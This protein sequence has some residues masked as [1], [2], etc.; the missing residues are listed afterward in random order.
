[1]RA[2]GSEPE[3]TP[4]RLG[5]RMP[6]EWEPHAATWMAWPHA[7]DDWPGKLGAIARVYAAMV[8]ELSRGERV[9]IL[10]QHAAAGG[11]IRRAL[12][13]A[14][15]DLSAVRLH[16][17]PT[18]RSWT[19]DTLPIFVRN[20][21]EVALVDWRFNGWARYPD[22]RLDDA[23]GG[24]LAP[25]LGLRRFVP[26]HRTAGGSRRRVVLEGGAIDA[27]GAGLLL[28][29]EECLLSSTQARNPGLGRRATENILRAH[30]GVEKIVWLGRGIAGDDTHG[31]VDD[32]ARFVGQRTVVAVRE[33]NPD[34]PNHAPLAENLRRL[35]E[36]TDAVGRPLR[37]VTLPMPAPIV[38][39]GERLPASYA[40]FYL[41]NGLVLVPTFDD[42]NDAVALRTLSDLFPSRR[43]VGIHA[44]DLLVG[45]GSLHCVTQ[46]QPLI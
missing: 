4:A 3:L 31:H 9:E 19:R 17:V 25:R 33:D 38:H 18:D 34:D 8:R 27:N 12:G 30:L 1:M 24:R 32:L 40:N 21:G 23:I 22:W 2:P 37:V 6:A 36:E 44:V 42:E 41:A 43:V 28:T 39:E 46:P 15:A 29:T 13:D 7:A 5:F 45:R 26:R 10:I 14:G 11:Q 20:S 35:G 16:E